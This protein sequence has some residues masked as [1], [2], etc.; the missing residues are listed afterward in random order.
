MMAKPGDAPFASLQDA[1]DLQRDPK[2]IFLDAR[3]PE[4]FE[5]GRIAGA[6]PLPYYQL[7]DYQ[8]R[9]LN[10]ASADTVMVIYCEG[11][12]CELSFFLARELQSA[13][14]KNLRIFYGGYPEWQ[15]AGLPIEK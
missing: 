7:M 3:S 6:R 4:E 2:V 15:S 9:A 5:K 12:G 11:I 13:G 8:E 14:Y 10:G 1:I